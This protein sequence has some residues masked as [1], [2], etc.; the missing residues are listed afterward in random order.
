MKLGH[1][2]I[3]VGLTDRVQKQPTHDKYF[4]RKIQSQF[5]EELQRPF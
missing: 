2:E 5:S 4:L 1:Q 3:V